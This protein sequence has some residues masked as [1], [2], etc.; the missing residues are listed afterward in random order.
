MT[1]GYT[2]IRKERNGVTLMS[3][4]GDSAYLTYEEY[5]SFKSRRQEISPTNDP[6]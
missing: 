5:E 3:D 2:L 4:C 1:W 6:H